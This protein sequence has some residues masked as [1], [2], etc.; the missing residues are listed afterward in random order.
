MIYISMAYI[1]QKYHLN[2]SK[3]KVNATEI[4]KNTYSMITREWHNVEMSNWF[5]NII[6]AKANKNCIWYFRYDWK[7]LTSWRN[8]W[9]HNIPFMSWHTFWCHDDVFDL[10]T[11]LSRIFDVM[12]NFL[13]SWCVSDVMTTFLVSWRVFD[14]MTNCLASWRVF[15]VM[16][17]LLT[18]WR[19]LD[20]M[21]NVLT[22]WCALRT[23]WS[24]NSPLRLRETPYATPSGLPCSVA[25]DTASQLPRKGGY[26]QL[27]VWYIFS[28]HSLDNENLWNMLYC[29]CS[30]HWLYQ[31]WIW[32]TCRWRT[33]PI[34]FPPVSII[35]TCCDVRGGGVYQD[36]NSKIWPPKKSEI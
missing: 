20:I 18:S 3:V 9:R 33:R 34:W 1:V 16:T 32:Y 10:M 36:L 7:F 11:Y 26:P 29:M 19:N 4:V 31:E 14:V 25:N 28:F 24:I 12:T 23:F 17:N 30:L 15:D 13:T 21:T 27:Q 2:R 5:Q 8:F 35:R 6:K 22:S